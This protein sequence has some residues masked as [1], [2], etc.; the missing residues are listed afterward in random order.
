[1]S[2]TNS[3]LATTQDA[4]I[5][6]MAPIKDVTKWYNEFVDFTKSILK[7][8]LDYGKIPGVDKP[9]LLKAGAEKIRFVYGL[10]T[11][12]TVTN[13]EVRVEPYPFVS[14]SYK[15]TV[16]KNGVVL[17][18]CEGNVNSGESKYAYIWV[19]EEELPEGIDTTKLKRR[20]SKIQ[21][22]DFAINKAET[23]GEYGK[24]KEYWD[25]WKKAMADG[26]AT[27]IMRKTKSGK[28]MDGWEMGG[29]TYRIP[30]EDVLGLENTIMK[31]AQ[32][33]AF[34]GAIMMATGAS[35][36]FT[37]DIED[38]GIVADIDDKPAVAAIEGQVVPEAAPAP[39]TAVKKT[40]K[41]KDAV[42][43]KPEEKPAAQPPTNEAGEIDMVKVVATRRNWLKALSKSGKIEFAEQ[44]I[45]EF[46]DEE[47]NEVFLDY[48]KRIGK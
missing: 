48:K 45:L 22:F 25:N 35:E 4:A 15:C 3:Q 39:K 8:N 23:T 5:L 17:A 19:K 40:T 26:R 27:K 44:D 7:E 16:T 1:M 2:E 9:T 41:A 20:S 29:Y 38:L 6:R 36:F 10:S 18:E 32:K 46:S 13:K 28:E 12:M 31:M 47:V 43:V 34:V 30:N 24:P 14:Y 42:E 21:E 37:Q 33:R 11:T